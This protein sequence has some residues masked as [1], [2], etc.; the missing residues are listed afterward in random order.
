[1]SDNLNS[2]KQPEQPEQS[3]DKPFFHH[4][5]PVKNEKNQTEEKSQKEQKDQKETKENKKLKKKMKKKRVLLPILAAVLVFLG[6][7]YFTI[8]SY[9]YQ[10]T[11]DAFVEGHIISVAPRVEGQIINL[12]VDD[13]QHLEEGQ[14]IAEIDPKDY[15]VKLA[16]AEAKLQEAKASLNMTDKQVEQN[17]ATLSQYSQDIHSTQSKLNFAKEDYKRYNDMY[18]EGIVSKQDYDNSMTNLH[19]A[20][21]NYNSAN[22]RVKASES[23][24]QSSKARKAAVEAE[25]KRL[26]AEVE[27]AK[28]NLSYTKIYAPQEGNVTARSVEKGNYVNVAQPLLAI[29]P[30]KVWVV[31]NFK[32]TQLESMKPGQPVSIKIDTYPHKVFKGKVDSIQR[33]TGAKASLFPPENAVGSYVKIVQRVPVKIV[34]DEDYSQYNIVPG[35][36]VIPEV[37]VR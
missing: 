9:F 7:V 35:M 29:V 19:V 20:Q 1:M 32:E 30:T 21:A 8:H 27:Q 22:D 6:G 14:L 13:N 23:S 11:D 25:I 4:G 12:Y 31:A 28:L 24:L 26:E 36:S 15:E 33:A 2:P 5:Q 10:S 37:K 34:F 3:G 18:K 16:Q 17:E